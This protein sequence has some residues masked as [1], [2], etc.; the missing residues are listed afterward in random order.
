MQDAS[1]NGKPK[2][3]CDATVSPARLAHLR[4]EAPSDASASTRSR[5]KTIDRCGS[6]A[7]RNGAWRSSRS[8]MRTT[9]HPLLKRI[10][11]PKRRKAPRT[12][13]LS[14]EA[15]PLDKSYFRGSKESPPAS[16][17]SSKY[18]LTGWG[19]TSLRSS[20]PMCQ[21]SVLGMP[22]MPSAT[23]TGSLP[24]FF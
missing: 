23:N 16:M 9:K 20:L 10:P 14:E 8:A 13:G 1:N 22:S 3:E 4:A 5:R 21:H 18:S 6:E 17:A 7:R 19:P 15:S 12:R 2:G 11:S 24:A